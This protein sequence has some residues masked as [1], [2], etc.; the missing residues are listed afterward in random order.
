MAARADL[1]CAQMITSS[2]LERRRLE[3]GMSISALSRRSGVSLAT[4]SRILRD[5]LMNSI[6]GHVVA[7]ANALG[8][9][10]TVSASSTSYDLREREAT[11][12]AERIVAITQGTSGLESQ[13]VNA[14]TRNQMVRQTVHE[15][16]AA[17]KSRLWRGGCVRREQS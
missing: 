14:E 16:M 6:Y 10:I 11:R 7:V 17:P 4:T 1:R 12:Q 5:R 8:M 2:D 13:A 15:L 3:L 9:D